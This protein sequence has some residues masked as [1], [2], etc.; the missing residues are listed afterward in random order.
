LINKP[1]D[2]LPS[3]EGKNMSKQD[4]SRSPDV[5]KSKVVATTVIRFVILGALMLAALF[6]SA[7][8]L[9]WWEGW[10]Y[11]AVS[12]GTMMA[13]RFYLISL[14]PGRLVER[15]EAP[16]QENVKAWDRPFVFLLGFLGP[17]IAWIV[18]GLDVRFGWSP[19]LPDNVQLMALAVLFLGTL[20]SN[21]AMIV[22]SFYSSH[23]RIQ[24]DRG[25]VVVNRGPYRFL[26]HPGYAG[27]V[28]AWTAVPFFF[29]S[30]WIAIPTIVVILAY[31]VRIV[32]EDR[33]LQ[34]ELPGYKEYASKVRYRLVPGIW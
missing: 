31:V 25:H 3:E 19:D 15:M 33:T 10:A 29:S 17:L 12:L 30:Y 13:S 6:L 24:G 8:R 22:N 20:L 18:A 27:D 2:G 28:W 34:N 16:Q 23:V 4:P 5:E 11:V 32:L 7:G 1:L 26:R 14:D 9:D 21:W